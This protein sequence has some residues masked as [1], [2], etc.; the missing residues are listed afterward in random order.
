MKALFW[1]EWRENL[2]WGLLAMAAIAVAMVYALRQGGDSVDSSWAGLQNEQFLTVTAFGFP[3][4]AL[5]LGFLQI[6]TELRR[7]QWAFLL[8]RPVTRLQVFWGKALPGTALYLVA[9]GLPLAASAYWLSLPGSI[10]APFDIRQILPGSVNLLA[11]LSYYYAALLISILPGRWYGRKVLP[12]AAALLGSTFANTIILSPALIGPIIVLTSMIIAAASAHAASGL[13]RRMSVVGKCGI[14]SVYL[15]GLLVADMVLSLGWMMLFPPQPLSYQR[16]GVDQ[17][18]EVVRITTRSNWYE[19]VETLDG[20]QIK[21]EKRAFEW[22]DFLFP[23]MLYYATPDGFRDFRSPRAYFTYESSNRTAPF[24]WYYIN[25]LGIFRVYSTETKMP[26]GVLGPNG[27][28]PIDNTGQAGRFHPGFSAYKSTVIGDRDGVYIPDLDARSVKKIY[29]AAPGEQIISAA[30]LP[31]PKKEGAQ[32]EYAIGSNQAIQVVTKSGPRARI[33]L[34]VAPNKIT[35]VEFYRPE[36]GNYTLFIRGRFPQGI[37]LAVASP[38]GKITRQQTLP[39]LYNSPPQSISKWLGEALTPLGARLLG[40]GITQ[41]LQFVENGY[42]RMVTEWNAAEKPLEMLRWL[43]AAAVGL[44]CA[45][46]IQ[47]PLKRDQFAGQ[48]LAWTVFAFF[49]G[50]FGL[51]AFWI[52]NDWPR[53]L[54]CPSC[55]RKRSV[56]R[57]TCEHCGAGWPAPKQDGTEIW[58]GLTEE[59][60]PP[61]AR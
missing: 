5:A 20:K 46:L 10:A 50:V 34:P 37:E 55:S 56:E 6:L 57:E 51:L 45:A 2:K 43:A 4:I 15:L 42:Y 28:A 21:P 61:A 12:L 48:R 59:A 38:D 24:A 19:K 16:Y 29:A 39:L 36:S 60:T 52:A 30:R 7:D 33:A 54:A 58:E 14:L 49:F 23:T 25:D 44:L 26:L 47:I 53:R 32:E 31:K 40:A 9:G 18:G 8:H 41:A 1:K 27:Y 11:G 35:G 3:V 17:N 22:A 13:F